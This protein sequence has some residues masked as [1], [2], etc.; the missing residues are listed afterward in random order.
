MVF[1]DIVCQVFLS[2]LAEYV[3]MFFPDSISDPIKSH[4]YCSRFFCFA[5]LL[6]M[7]FASV[8]YVATGVGG[9]RRPISARA[10]LIEVAFWQFSNDPLSSSSVA[11]AMTF[12]TMLHFTCTGT[13]YGGIYFIG[14]LDFGPRKVFSSGSASCI[15]FWYVVCIRL[16]VENH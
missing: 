13:F 11:D 16:Y 3:E 6:T 7:L 14:V 15:R 9:C 2:L 5:V 12:L 1:C 4:I 10:V 8:L